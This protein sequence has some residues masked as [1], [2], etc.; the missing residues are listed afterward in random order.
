CRGWWRGRDR[1]EGLVDGGW[2]GAGRISAHGEDALARGGEVRAAGGGHRQGA[3]VPVAVAQLAHDL[4]GCALVAHARERDARM[5]GE[6][7]LA[8]AEDAPERALLEAL[9]RRGEAELAAQLDRRGCVLSVARAELAPGHLREDL[10]G[11]RVARPGEEDRARHADLRSL[12]RIGDERA[13]A[14]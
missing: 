11:A 4:A 5:P 2:I 10:D 8:D 14:R 13:G 6:R 7:I 1:R 12:A 3:Y 9:L